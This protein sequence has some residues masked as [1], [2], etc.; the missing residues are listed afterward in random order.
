MKNDFHNP[1]Y[2]SLYQINTRVWLTELSRELGRRATLDDIPD[3]ALDQFSQQGFDWIWLLSVWQTGVAAQAISRSNPQWQLEFAETLPDLTDTDIAGSGFAITGY[4]VHQ[5]L[6]GDVALER[7]RERM[8]QRG[9]KLML[10]F[11]PNH[12]APD[13]PWVEE[14]P[15]YF[16]GGS[17][18]DLLREPDNFFRST[19]NRS[20][21]VF[22]YGRDPYFS[23]WPDTIQLNYG[24]SALQEAMIG[25]LMRISEM[26]DGVRCDMAMLLLPEVFRRTWNIETQPFWPSAISR[27]QQNHP[28]FVFMAEVYW[29]LEWELQQ[30][31]FDFC[32]DKR[33]YD[34]LRDGEVIAIRQHLTAELDFQNR[35]ARFLENHDESRAASVF[36]QEKHRAAAIIN[37]LSPGLRF[38]HQGQLEGC[39]KK[40]SPHLVRAPQESTDTSLLDFYCQLLDVLR[41]HVVRDGTWQL[42]ECLEAWNGNWTHDCFVAFGWQGKFE[43]PIVA[44]INY[45][46]HPAQCRVRVPF[47]TPFLKSVQLR[48]LINSSVYDRDAMSITTEGL[49]VDLPA[50]G[51]HVFEITAATA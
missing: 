13:H 6:G 29:D 8:Q 25:E 2:P 5:D 14:H 44:I 50:W 45:S 26:C 24:N 21:Q 30:Q 27:V 43:I 20:S 9:I 48:D 33:L 36:T 12:I 4:H 49:F 19:T 42:L 35:L 23:G 38:F 46:E 37:Y 40:I 11:V 3:Y 7:L 16:V 31:G 22:A 47:L 41:R 34:R 32:Y 18:D 17:E 39:R 1:R 51:R 10:D 15:Q 28:E